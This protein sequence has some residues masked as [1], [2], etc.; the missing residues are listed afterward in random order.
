MQHEERTGTGA[1]RVLLPFLASVVDTW[2]RWMGL[3]KTPYLCV[4][5]YTLLYLWV[6]DST[7]APLAPLGPDCYSQQESHPGATPHAYVYHYQQLSHRCWQS[8][9]TLT[10]RLRKILERNRPPNSKDPYG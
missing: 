8:T 4:N 9:I 5:L 10:G 3:E 7:T 1:F 6:I 2:K